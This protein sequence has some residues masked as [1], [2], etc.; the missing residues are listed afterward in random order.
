M[1][2]LTAYV[3]DLGPTASQQNLTGA[4]EVVDDRPGHPVQLMPTI[5][6]SSLAEPDLLIEV[7]AVAVLG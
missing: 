5:G 3:V 4:G 1:V 7:E 6:I 2:R